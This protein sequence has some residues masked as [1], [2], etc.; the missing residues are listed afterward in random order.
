MLNIN[1]K[2]LCQYCFAQLSPKMKSCP[3]CSGTKNN[4]K[5]PTA[6]AEG[7]ILMGRYVVGKVLG[8]GGFGITYLCYDSK[9]D[10][11]VAVKEYLPDSLTHRNSGESIVH[12]Y[13]DDRETHFHTGV[14]KFYEEARLVSRFNGNPNIISVYEFFYENNTTYFVMEYL[15]GI[16]FKNY[17]FS[18]GGKISESE[19]VY[20]L[21]HMG[22]ALM[23]VHSTGILH[24]D[25][26]P[27][28]IFL[29]QN[30]NIK[31]IDFGAARQVLGEASKSLSVIL[32]QGFAPLEQYQKHG[33]Q[34]PWTDIYALGATMYF[35]VTGKLVDDAM[36]RLDDDLLDLTGVSE[37]FGAILRKMLSVKMADRYQDVFA[38]KRDLAE[39]EMTAKA[40]VLPEKKETKN[41]CERCGSEIAA[42][43]VL[44]EKCQS[45]GDS[46]IKSMFQPSK[47]IKTETKEKLVEKKVRKPK[48][49]REKKPFVSPKIDARILKIGGAV[50]A[51][52]VVLTLSIVGVVSVVN[53]NRHA[54]RIVISTDTKKQEESQHV[55]ISNVPEGIIIAIW[56][57]YQLSPEIKGTEDANPEYAS[58]NDARV[59]VDENGLVGAIGM[60]KATVTV[61]CGDAKKTVEVTVRKR[62]DKV[63]LQ[64]NFDAATALLSLVKNDKT[65]NQSNIATYI[66]ALENL[67]RPYESVDFSTLE[68]VR[69]FDIEEIY[70]SEI[71]EAYDNLNSAYETEKKKVSTTT[72]TTNKK[73]T[74]SGSSGSS[75]SSG[76]SSGS[77]GSSG[78]SSGSS[79]SSGG[80]SGSSGSSGDSGNV[81]KNLPQGDFSGSLGDFDESQGDFFK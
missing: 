24:R 32:K 61:T 55:T 67:V 30:G 38:V 20:I 15:D 80:S 76:G 79:G 42:G 5:Y 68:Q 26:S 66:T 22:E 4:D 47:K 8:K 72:T 46:K 73:T 21:S 27:D 77:S 25:I 74:K 13:T 52:V 29:C 44:C 56:D 71:K 41:F 70:N 23:V 65:I 69:L 53:N 19:A 35:A 64:A 40:P 78:G 51:G 14:K 75:G 62:V 43:A 12:A 9:E 59:I 81:Y 60:G 31:L 10:R 58:S 16:D 2:H 48:E 50:I 37:K 57:S 49:K 45:T 63:Q 39:L 18:H 54:E 7:L 34:G 36:S 3:Y 17:I 28:N 33:K 11:T 1:N 6:L